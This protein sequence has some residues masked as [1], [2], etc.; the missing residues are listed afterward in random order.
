MRVLVTGVK[1]Q[2]GYDVV[3]HLEAR[4]IENRGVDIEDFD[5]T[6]EAAVRAYVREYRPTCIVHCAAY[7]AV[8]RAESEPEKC[9]A[10]NVTGTRN[11]AL[12][13]KDVDAEVLYVSTDYVFDG[14]SKESP[15]EADDPKG[16]QNVYGKTKYE[17]ELEIEKLLDRY[18]IVRICWVFGKNGNNFVKTM[19]RLAQSHDEISVVCDQ[20]GAPTY[21]YDV[22]AL[23][24]DIIA[25]HKYGVYQAP[26]GGDITWYDFA[27]EIF[28]Q[29]GRNVTVHPVSTEEYAKMNPQAAARPKNSRM[30]QKALVE[31]GF[32][33][34][35]DYKD[36]LARYLKEL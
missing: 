31:A 18:Y 17:G 30:S 3:R 2:L 8:D 11:I 4:G 32:T 14:R 28:R 27:V 6:D 21:T 16:P 26:N 10:V 7:T 20:H 1:G 36:A 29:A 35:P 22:A 12:A 5:L 23:M 34:L 19:L 9:F 25:S 33:P 24:C 15:W 13:A